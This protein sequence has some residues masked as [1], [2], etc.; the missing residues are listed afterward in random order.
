MNADRIRDGYGTKLIDTMMQTK[1]VYTNGVLNTLIKKCEENKNPGMAGV[2]YQKD[3][4]IFS[5]LQPWSCQ[6]QQD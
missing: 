4:I 3:L 2:C 1:T 6:Y 5:G